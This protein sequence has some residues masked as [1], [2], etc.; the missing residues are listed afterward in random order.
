[1]FNLTLTQEQANV[2]IQLLDIATK[3]G[4]LQAAAPALGFVQLIQEA[5]QKAQQNDNIRS[6]PNNS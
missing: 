2:L 4:G 3:A 1:M 5:Q 6:E